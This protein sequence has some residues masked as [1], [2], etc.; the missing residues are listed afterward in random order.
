MWCETA[1]CERPI[2]A[3]DVAGAEAPL[4]ARDQVAAGPSPGA[5][6]VQDLQARRVAESLEDQNEVAGSVS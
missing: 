6:E 2:G 5:Q 3:L 4:V 1:A